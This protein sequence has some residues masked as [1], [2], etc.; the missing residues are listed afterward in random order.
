VESLDTYHNDDSGQV[1]CKLAKCFEKR[2]FSNNVFLK[3]AYLG[4]NSQNYK[5]CGKNPK[6]LNNSLA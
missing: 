6:K 1:W 4:K 5:F 3:F 2:I